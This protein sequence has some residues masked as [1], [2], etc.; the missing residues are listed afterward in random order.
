MSK[1]KRRKFNTDETEQE[2]AKRRSYRLA[3]ALSFYPLEAPGMPKPGPDF[4]LRAKQHGDDSEFK[5]SGK[6]EEIINIGDK[7]TSLYQQAT[8]D[9]GFGLKVESLEDARL[10]IEVRSAQIRDDR[11]RATIYVPEG[12]LERFVKKIERYEREDTTPRTEE[13]HPRPK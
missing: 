6:N 7:L 4:R 13:G 5:G 1:D 2:I 9:L 11:L 12:K 8:Y 3:S 10:G